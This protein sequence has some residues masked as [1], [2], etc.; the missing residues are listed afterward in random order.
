MARSVKNSIRIGTIFLFLLVVATGGF[1]IYYIVKIRNQSKNVLKANYESIEFCHRMQRTLDSMVN[2]LPVASGSFQQQLALQERNITEPG[3]RDATALLRSGFQRLEAGDSSIAAISSIRH[4]LQQIL[5]INMSAVSRRISASENEAEE[6]MTI[7]ITIVA[8]IL[9]IGF[10]FSFNFPSVLT[11]PIRKLAEAIREIGQKN[12]RHRVHINSRDEFGQLAEAFNEMAE[13]LE[14]FE[15]SNLNKLMFEKSRAE[16]VIN[17]LKDASIGIDKNGKILFANVQALQ[18]LGVKSADIVGKPSTELAAANDLFRHLLES[19]SSAPFKIVVDGKENYFVK[20]LIE[21]RQEETESR[22][23]VIKNITS[24]KELD[25]AKTN[26]IATISHELKTPLASSDFTVKLLQDERTGNLNEE[27]KELVQHIRDDN[28][29]I[30]KIL[31]ELLNLSQIETGRIQLNRSEARPESIVHSALQTVASAAREKNI[32]IRQAV[33]ADLPILYVDAEKTV[34]VLNNL[35][36][37]AIRYSMPNSVVDVSIRK[38]QTE[39]IF[40]IRDTGPG[41]AAEY[42]GRIFDRYFQVPG[43]QPTGT[44][45]GLAISRD[46]IE[47]QGGSIGVQSEIGQ[48]SLFYFTLPVS[49]G[50]NPKA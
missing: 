28:Q 44:G 43:S 41:I 10:T 50:N 36:A 16:A 4:Q 14:Y 27:Q 29:R 38:Q 18:L 1:G 47:S 37:N 24:F 31:S 30:L 19:D 45:L 9:I 5:S 17:S 7:L 35:L 22:V 46:F 8:M 15:N 2:H 3:E 6:A 39:L 21:V 49:A 12:Y 20:E 32:E 40:S 33:D 26:F 13:R 42:Q 34:W 11:D 23:I 25:E 48:G